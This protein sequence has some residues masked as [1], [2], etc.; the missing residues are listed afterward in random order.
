MN[1]V[2]ARARPETSRRCSSSC[3]RWRPGGDGDPKIVS[4]CSSPAAPPPPAGPSRR[5][6]CS[7]PRDSPTRPSTPTPRWT[8]R[9]GGLPAR[10]AVAAIVPPRRTHGWPLQVEDALSEIAAFGSSDPASPGVASRA[11]AP[12]DAAVDAL[13]AFLASMPEGKDAT[14]GKPEPVVGDFLSEFS[15]AP[16]KAFVAVPSQTNYCAASF[17]TVPYAHEDAAPLFLLG[18]AMSTEFLHRE[19]REK[20][21]AYGGPARPSPIEVFAMSCVSRP[22]RTR[23]WRRSRRRRS[24]RR[25]RV[26][27]RR[28]SSRRRTF[29]RSNP[30]TRHSRRPAADP[31]CSPR[32][33]P[34]GLEADAF[35]DGLLEC[36][37]ER[38]RA[39]A[40]KYLVGKTPALAIVGG[41]AA[42][43]T[44]RG[45][46][47]EC[48]DAE[49]AP[50]EA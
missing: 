36:T 44:L 31:S 12:A 37:A 41:P 26:P 43:E 11:G 4:R 34:D 50:Y 29:A 48:L 42:A 3:P 6:A 40:E 19:L 16:S 8:T 49:G 46:G 30:S 38:M 39:C 9:I 23:R 20:G 47:W 10:P 1:L 32:G 28:R 33:S 27:S 35:K 15:P 25:R 21:G 17:A 2:R 24:G 22:G 14:A 45:E 13:D 5:T 7:T 18:Q